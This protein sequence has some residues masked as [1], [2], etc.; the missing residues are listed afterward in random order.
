MFK[1][2]IRSISTKYIRSF[3]DRAKK[4]EILSNFLNTKHLKFENGQKAQ[5]LFSDKEFDRRLANLRWRHLHIC[6]M[7]RPKIYHLLGH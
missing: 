7:F 1:K 2:Y 5:R 6:L 4:D 3:S